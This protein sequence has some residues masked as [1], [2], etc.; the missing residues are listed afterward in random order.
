MNKKERKILYKG[1]NLDTFL[2][3][4]NKLDSNGIKYFES[5]KTNGNWFIFFIQLFMIGT[6]SYGMTGERVMHYYIY[7]ESEDYE[8]A[9]HLIGAISYKGR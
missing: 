4:K 3:I 9:I 5:N 2:F 6:G 1:T 7:V 8:A